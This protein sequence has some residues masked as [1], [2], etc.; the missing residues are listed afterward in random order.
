MLL[1][2]LREKGPK[3]FQ[4]CDG[5]FPRTLSARLAALPCACQGHKNPLTQATRP[6][7]WCTWTGP[8]LT[9]HLDAWGKGS[10]CSITPHPT[11]P[12]PPPRKCQVC[13]FIP[14][15]SV[16]TTPY[17]Q[18]PMNKQ[19]GTLWADLF[20]KH[21]GIYRIC[22]QTDQEVSSRRL[23]DCCSGDIVCRALSI[24]AFHRSL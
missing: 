15:T 20:I 6:I 14:M 13:Y 3:P 19:D 5:G 21:A 17:L 11:P 2:Y 4:P 23:R 18:H 22:S 12:H 16:S 1:W 7:A 8:W 10:C 24:S 9:S